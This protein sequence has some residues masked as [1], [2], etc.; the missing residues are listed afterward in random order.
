MLLA[1]SITPSGAAWVEDCA[2][3]SVP[4]AHVV[5]L[6][7]F[8]DRDVVR[9]LA[10][11][12]GVHGATRVADDLSG[13]LSSIPRTAMFVA[14]V[15][16]AQSRTDVTVV[17]VDGSVPELIADTCTFAALLSVS[18][19]EF[20]VTERL[21]QVRD[22]IAAGEIDWLLATPPESA[23]IDAA[24]VQVA[25]GCALGLSIRGVLVAPMPRKV[26]GWPASIRRSARAL[27]DD[28]SDKLFPVPIARVRGGSVHA[29]ER[30]DHDPRSL[31]VTEDSDGAYLLS[32]TIPGVQYCDLEVGVW[33]DDPSYPATHLVLR[34]D[35]V[36]SRLGLDS[37]LRRCV[38]VEAV[39]AGDTI[40]VPFIPDPGQWPVADQ[41]EDR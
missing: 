21:Q 26:D 13:A 19:P 2:R 35:G 28:L 30:A 32:L 1:S 23:A 37:T 7:H 10:A 27:V 29:F 41:S 14:A 9:S 16:F 31:T 24:T 12:I 20:A 36:A 25:Q 38:A 11:V 15:E 17:R 39:V 34:L 6:V 22:A 40:T 33:S 5:E 4:S 3:A 8:D 18:A